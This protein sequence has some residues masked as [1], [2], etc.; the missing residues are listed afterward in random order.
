MY[1]CFLILPGG[2]TSYI[3]S[4]DKITFFLIS[5]PPQIY[6]IYDYVARKSDIYFVFCKAVI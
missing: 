3:I 4:C 5:I 2:L 1:D 6:K